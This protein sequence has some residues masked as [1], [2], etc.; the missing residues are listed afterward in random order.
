MYLLA[1]NTLTFT[2]SGNVFISPSSPEHISTAYRIWDRQ[3]LSFC[4]GKMSHH[5]FRAPGVLMRRPKS[6]KYPSHLYS[7]S[8]FP[9]YFWQSDWMFLGMNPFQFILFGVHSASRISR[10]ISLPN[11]GEPLPQ[12]FFSSSTPLSPL[13]VGSDDA[14]IWPFITDLQVPQA[15]FVTSQCFSS[16]FRMVIFYWLILSSLRLFCHLLSATASFQWCCLK[17]SFTYHKNIYF[18]SKISIWV[19]FTAY[20]SF[21]E[22]GSYCC[23]TDYHKR[24]DL[25]EHTFP[26]SHILS[27][28]S[29]AGSSTWLQLKCWPGPYSH[30]RLVWW[31]V[32]GCSFP[33]GLWG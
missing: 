19:F 3:I 22:S 12:F 25:K 18:S 17:K 20:T 15:K 33:F 32:W 5:T 24:C 13:F 21:A 11:L 26:V 1:I 14:N 2:L 9:S 7:R 29:W 23:V 31:Q 6:I 8:L 27:V 10:L 30:L 4:T 16:L 28:S